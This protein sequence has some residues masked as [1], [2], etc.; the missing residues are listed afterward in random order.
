MQIAFR[1]TGLSNRD[2]T[3]EE[4]AHF[5]SMIAAKFRCPEK[6]LHT[7]ARANV[8]RIVSHKKSLDDLLA[9]FPEIDFVSRTIAAH[10]ISLN[11]LV[12]FK[13]ATMGAE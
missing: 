5:A 10:E 6:S 3:R 7:S 12:T 13:L 4:Q 1:I 9:A 8:V 2:T 11:G